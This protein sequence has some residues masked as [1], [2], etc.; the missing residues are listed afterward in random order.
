VHLFK[1][2]IVAWRE[3]GHRVLITCRDKDVA[4]QL[5]DSYGFEYISTGM[6]GKGRAGMGLEMLRRAAILWKIASRFNPDVFVGVGGP[7]YVHVGWAKRI[8]S[9]VFTDTEHAKLSNL[10]SFPFA[11]VIC[12]PACYKVDLGRKQIRYNGYQELAYLH[13]S[14]FAPDPS[15]CQE[16]GIG[17]GERFFVIRFVSWG[18]VHDVGHAG[19]STSAKHSLVRQLE[20]LGRVIISSESNLPPELQPYRMTVSPAR[21][22]DLLSFGCLYVGEGATMASEAAMLGIP[23]IY[24]SSLTA[25]TLEEEERA[26]GLV[27]RITD[28]QQAIERAVE[29]ASRSGQQEEYRQRRQRLLADK[30]DVTAWMVD[31]VDYYASSSCER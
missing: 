31:L 26:Y 2:A 10:I 24:V 22:H 16:A 5:L 8:P 4:H 7:A 30:I 18:A 28:E 25:G 1:H 6:A 13:P 12:T 9:F 29:L 21:I 15:V 23:S 11:T 20:K 14:Y 19:F 27:H 3:R 17:P